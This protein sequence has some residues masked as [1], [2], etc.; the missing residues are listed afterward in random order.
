M[1]VLTRAPHRSHGSDDFLVCGSLGAFGGRIRVALEDDQRGGARRMCRR[2]QRRCRERSVDRQEDRFATPEIVQ[3]CGD[4]VGPLLQRRQRARRDG[5]RHSGTRLVKEDQPTQR[6]HRLHPALNRRQLRKDLTA[7]EP[8]RHQDD[9]ASAFR[10]RA[11]GDTQI[12]VHRIARLR[13]HG[14]SLSRGGD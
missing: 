3:D 12:P 10:R 6:C 1:F 4:A 11:I 2:K 7:R 8:V 9:V 13:E 5:I 14:G